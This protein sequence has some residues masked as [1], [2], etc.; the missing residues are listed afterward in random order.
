MAARQ[1]SAAGTAVGLRRCALVMWVGVFLPPTSQ[2]APRTGSSL[3]QCANPARL[4]CFLCLRW[5]LHSVGAGPARM[6]FS[7]PQ[8]EPQPGAPGN[9]H[10]RCY[11][12]VS[13]DDTKQAYRA[14][15]IVS[16]GGKGAPRHLGHY[17]TSDDAAEAVN[18][19]HQLLAEHA[20]PRMEVDPRPNAV[21]PGASSLGTAE[22]RRVIK[23]GCAAL[24]GLWQADV[25]AA[26]AREIA[27]L[28]SCAQYHAACQL[29]PELPSVVS[30]IADGGVQPGDLVVKYCMAA[31]PKAAVLRQGGPAANG[32]RWPEEIKLLTAAASA[33]RSGEGALSVVRGEVGD[34]G[35]PFPSITTNRRTVGDSGT[36]I[37][38][39]DRV[40]VLPDCVTRFVDSCFLAGLPNADACLALDGVDLIVSC[41]VLQTA[42]QHDARLLLLMLR[43]YC[44]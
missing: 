41:A 25:D 43:C 33:Q 21:P 29:V 34:P 5:Y 44:F 38:Q 17:P 12:G 16:L 37:A 9:V 2:T 28:R 40:G 30:A 6:L 10:V 24:S 42:A 32:V 7:P 13:W 15:S 35:L 4:T 19:F 31:V 39:D 26:A 11:A 20:P 1:V 36:A 14:R 23:C 18:L 8:P 3:M 27:A 22:E